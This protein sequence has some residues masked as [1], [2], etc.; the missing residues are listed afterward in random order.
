MGGL[1]APAGLSPP[2]V[3]GSSIWNRIRCE[4]CSI[5]GIGQEV[6]TFLGPGCMEMQL[7]QCSTHSGLPCVSP[8][9]TSPPIGNQKVV[10]KTHGEFKDVDIASSNSRGNAWV[11]VWFKLDKMG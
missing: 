4:S 11:A 6:I 1:Y 7:G 2:T 8:K 9:A 10:F 3:S 5:L